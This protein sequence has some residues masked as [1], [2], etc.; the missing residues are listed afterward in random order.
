MASY[1]LLMQFRFDRILF[2]SED[3]ELPNVHEPVN[4]YDKLVSLV[5]THAPMQV[6]HVLLRQDTAWYTEDLWNELEMHRQLYAETVNTLLTKICL[7][8]QHMICD[9]G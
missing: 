5:R 9:T 8:F 3:L 2:R 4:Q 1:A 6:K 7:L